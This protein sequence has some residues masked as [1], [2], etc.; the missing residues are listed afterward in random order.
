MIPVATF[1]GAYSSNERKIPMQYVSFQVAAFILAI[2]CFLSIKNWRP[3][4][5]LFTSTISIPLSLYVALV[6]IMSN[7]SF[8][9]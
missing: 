1:I 6:V 9:G 8:W 4:D 5:V 3:F 2:I 7:A